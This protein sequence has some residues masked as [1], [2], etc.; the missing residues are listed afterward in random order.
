MPEKSESTGN[1]NEDIGFVMKAGSSGN[2]TRD[3]G[4][5]KSRQ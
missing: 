3:K 1:L 2:T 5:C 4:W